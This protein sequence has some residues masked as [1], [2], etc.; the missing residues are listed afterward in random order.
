MKAGIHILLLI[1]IILPVKA[2]H[3]QIDEK[4]VNDFK[5]STSKNFTKHDLNQM[6]RKY[7]HYLTA[8]SKATHLAAALQGDT[9]SEY[10][11]SQLKKEKF[12]LKT[13]QKLLQSKNESQR[14]LSYLVIAAANDQSKESVLLSRLPTE[15]KGI[16]TW[17]A[18]SLLYLKTNHTTPVFDFFTTRGIESIFEAIPSFNLLNQ[19]S[20]QQTAVKRISSSNMYARIGAT[21]LMSVTSRTEE[22]ERLLREALKNWDWKTKGHVVHAMRYQGIGNLKQDLAPLLD[23][24]KTRQVA[25]E[26]LADS[27]SQEDQLFLKSLADSSANVSAPLLNSF[28]NSRKVDNVRYWLQLLRTKELPE[29]YYF[30]ASHQPLLYSD[31]CL[32]DLQISLDEIQNPQILKALIRALKGRS[33]SES[34][35]IFIKLL[36]HNDSGVRYWTAGTLNSVELSEKLRIEVVNSFIDKKRRTEP[37]ATNLIKYKVDTLQSQFEDIY[38]NS[39]NIIWKNVA[40]QYLSNFPLPTHITIFQNILSDSDED[41]YIQKRYASLGLAKLGDETSIELIIDA[42]DKEAIKSDV[43]CIEYLR[44]LS[45]LKGERAKEVIK[46]F[47]NSNELAVKTFASELLME[48]DSID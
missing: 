28:F 38:L 5:G 7:P 37:L 39:G 1:T 35:S 13:I 8:F 45:I 46:R 44:A 32:A 42:C 17:L 41:S 12:Y 10:P 23:S 36:R 3:G 9:I 47:T 43:N 11:L 25:M 15:E 14:L 18:F 21:H 33:D 40:I 31:E 19:D 4:F 26:A 29:D 48:W 2:T 27:P 6:L 16:S 22:S 34:E 24:S 30:F 20:L